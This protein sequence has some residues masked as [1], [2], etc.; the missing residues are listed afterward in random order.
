MQP[1]IQRTITITITETWTI[2][3][4]DGHATTWAETRTWPADGE[5]NEGLPVRLA[6][7]KR[8]VGTLAPTPAD[9]TPDDE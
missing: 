6:D 9:P 8:T 2:T 3:W 4:A 7:D 1:I 5:P